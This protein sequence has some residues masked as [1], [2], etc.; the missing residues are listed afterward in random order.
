MF[1]YITLHYITFF[2]SMSPRTVLEKCE[3]LDINLIMASVR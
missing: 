1:D 3:V 2:H